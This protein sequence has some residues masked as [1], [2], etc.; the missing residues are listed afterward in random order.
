MCMGVDRVMLVDCGRLLSGSVGV[1][2]GLGVRGPDEDSL[3]PNDK[4]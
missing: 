1:L 3:T 2:S 4:G